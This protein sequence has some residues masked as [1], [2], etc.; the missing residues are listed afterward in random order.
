MSPLSLRND[1]MGGQENETFRDYKLLFVI[2]IIKNGNNHLYII[3]II[4]II[5]I[6]K[7]CVTI[8]CHDIAVIIK[9]FSSEL[10]ILSWLCCSLVFLVE[11]AVV[12]VW[13]LS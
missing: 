7:L 11:V 9:L 4:I 5:T 12:T 6:I 8:F 3:I 13:V 1:E 10:N 2:S